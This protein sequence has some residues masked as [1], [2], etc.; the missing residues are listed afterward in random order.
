MWVLENSTVHRQ[1]NES[2][3]DKWCLRIITKVVLTLDTAW[4]GPGTPWGPQAPFREPVIYTIPDYLYL[5]GSVSTSFSWEWWGPKWRQNSHIGQE[6][7]MLWQFLCSTFIKLPS[8]ELCFR[9]LGSSSLTAQGNSTAQMLWTREMRAPQIEYP[10]FTARWVRKWDNEHFIFCPFCISYSIKN[11][12]K[13]THHSI[14][15][16]E[17]P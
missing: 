7:W 16:I 15:S 12:W 8:K 14:C 4:K 3:K 5:G 6:T 2:E 10:R 9:A 1:E 17:F 13:Y 11:I